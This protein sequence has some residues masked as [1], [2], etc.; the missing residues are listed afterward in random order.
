MTD[1]QTRP[2][3]REPSDDHG[4]LKRISE[5]VGARGLSALKST[6]GFLQRNLSKLGSEYAYDFP[7]GFPTSDT[8]AQAFDDADLNR[9]IAAY[10]FFYP[11]VSGMGILKGNEKV[12]V[13]P[14]RV[15]ATIDTKPIFVGYTLNSDTPYAPITLDLSIGP[16]V[17]ELPPGP[18]ISAILDIHQ[19]WIADMGLPGPDGGNGGKHLLLPPGYDGEEPEGFHIWRSQSNWIIGGARSIPVGGDLPAALDRLRTIKVYPLTP[20][21]SWVE[22]TWVDLSTTPIDSTPLKWEENLD[23]WRMLHQVIE[24]DAAIPD[25]RFAYGDLATLGIAKG[26][27]FSPDK[28]MT[29][30]LERAARIGYGQMRVESF[31]DRRPDRV[32]W[33]DRQWQWAALRFEDGGFNTAHYVDTYA[34]EK[35]FY[36]AIATSPAMFHRGAGSGSLYWLGLRDQAGDYLDGGKYY[37]LS[38]PQPV[39]GKLFWSVTVY[40]AYTRSQ[41]QADQGHA[42]LRSLFELSGLDTSVPAELYFGPTPPA[43]YERQWIQTLPDRGWFVY[44]RIYGPEESAFDGAWKPGDFEVVTPFA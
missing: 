39:P 8:E 17:V 6:K 19:N 25:Y 29:A 27:P 32:V 12:G 31:A 37:R 13:Y 3:T 11:T 30:I 14:N 26:Q 40:D 43:G 33:P 34:R 38:V 15:F 35:W 21:T 28:R 7:L 22:P 5:E 4:S 41:I 44:F 20:T 42:A 2:E 1:Q 16:I 24:G 23:F 10:R 18:L 36:Q 9:A